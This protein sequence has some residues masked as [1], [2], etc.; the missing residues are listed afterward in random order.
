MCGGDRH[1]PTLFAMDDGD[2][3]ERAAAE[4]QRVQRFQPRA[5]CPTAGSSTAAGNT[6]SGR[7][8]RCT[9]RSPC[10]RTARMVRPYYGNATIR[11]NVV[12]FPRPVPGS[13]KVMALFTGP[14]RA[15]ARRG[16]AD[17]RAPRHRRRRSRSPADAGRADDRREGRG[18]PRRLVQRP[19][20]AVGDD[21]ALLLHAHR[22]ALAGTDLGAVRGRSARQPGVGLP[23]PGDLLRRAGAAGGA[24]AA[25]RAA[26][27][28]PRAERRRGGRGH[29]RVDRRVPRADR[30]APRRRSG[31]CASSKT[32]RARA[33]TTAAWSAPP[34]R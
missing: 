32:C 2:G 14:P 9:T 3:S 22:A 21:L 19:A 29:A 6:T 8:R 27:P 23:R 11:P 30:R 16:G 24:A 33:C 25:A 13:H 31:T 5:C 1:A 10:T 15:D 34:A 28:R 20:A 26:R 7:S 17:R 12:M 4:L 18:Q